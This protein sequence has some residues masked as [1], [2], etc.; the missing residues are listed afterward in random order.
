MNYKKIN[1]YK[2]YL[3]YYFLSKFTFFQY[4]KKYYKMIYENI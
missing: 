1:K 2:Y 3:K 4:I